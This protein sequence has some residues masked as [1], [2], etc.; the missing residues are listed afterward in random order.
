MVKQNP[1]TNLG[2][3]RS[4]YL[5]SHHFLMF[6]LFTVLVVVLRIFSIT[7]TYQDK[8]PP[9]IRLSFCF[10]LKPKTTRFYLL[11]F[12]VSFCITR[13]HSLSIVVTLV[14]IIVPLVVTC[15]H[16]SICRHPFRNVKVIRHLHEC[17]LQYVT[18]D[19]Y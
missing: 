5:S 9:G 1:M 13:C 7:L 19:T 17:F 12:A 2:L 11:P 14:A 18:G 16:P 4:C 6:V 10:V 8:K 3:K 15:C